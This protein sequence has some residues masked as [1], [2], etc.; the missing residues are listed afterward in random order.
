MKVVLHERID[1]LGSRGDIV[2]VS[3]G[4]ARNSLIPKGLAQQATEGVTA[5]AEAMKR[6]WQLRNAKDRESAE[7]LA[8]T[9]VPQTIGI[10]ARASGE[11]KLFGSVSA[12]D[13]ADAVKEQTGIEL[14]RK[15]IELDETI[16]SVGTLSVMVKP[17]SEV[18][19]PLSVDV[20]A[21]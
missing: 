21:S 2:D 6:A 3:D 19:F 10:A 16:R 9:L 17:H 12:S 13:I 4:Y 20:T 15:M 18:A 8:K 14:D 5:Q 1:G 11:G 7:E